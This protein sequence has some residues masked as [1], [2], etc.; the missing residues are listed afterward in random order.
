MNDHFASPIY[1][2]CDPECGL[3]LGDP[4]LFYAAF[5]EGFPAAEQLTGIYRRMSYSQSCKTTLQY[6]A[7]KRENPPSSPADLCLTY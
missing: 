3:A 4:V 1:I 2:T 7:P 6:L 5:M